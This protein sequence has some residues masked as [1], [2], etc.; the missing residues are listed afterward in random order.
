MVD[1]HTHILPQID[2]GSKNDTMTYEILDLMKNQG[3]TAVVA[4]PHFYPETMDK[5]DFVQRRKE[6]LALINYDKI[7]IIKGCELLFHPCVMGY[8]NVDELCIEGTRYILI[9]LNYA[10]L[11]G[12][13]LVN[14]I[15]RFAEKFEIT[16]I[17]VHVERYSAIK[18]NPSLLDE[19]KNRGCL[20]QVNGDGFDSFFERRRLLKFIKEGKV[21]VIASDAHNPS[22]R[23]PNLKKA[24]DYIQKHL[25][26]DVVK[27][28]MNNA[29]II[30]ED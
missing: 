22:N 21:D 13:D 6:A 20:I 16:P 27:E 12:L 26:E 8:D 29:K 9:E 17:I 2:D 10:R 1:I 24:Y 25:G 5:E 28:L 30:V 15:E 19:F 14:A 3:I 23:K 4:S 11:W 18:K 7:K